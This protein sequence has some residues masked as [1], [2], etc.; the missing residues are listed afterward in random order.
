MG[1]KGVRNLLKSCRAR[2]HSQ[3]RRDGA[4]VYRLKDNRTFV[5]HRENQLSELIYYEGAYEPLESLIASKVILKNDV[6]LDVGANVGYYSALFDALVC[7]AGEVHSF[8]PGLKTFKHLCDTKSILNL[9]RTFVHQQAIGDHVGKCA[10]WIS[11]SGSDAQQSS[12]RVTALGSHTKQYEVDV[13][14]IDC[15]VDTTQKQN[16]RGVAFIK[17][18]IE[19]AEPAMLKGAQTL[20]CSADPPVWLIEHNRQALEE[21]GNSSSSLTDSFADYDIF[22]V[23]LTWPPSV[24]AIHQAVKWYG[25]PKH[26]PD[27]CN[28]IALPRRGRYAERAARLRECGLIT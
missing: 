8:E 17:C 1:R 4:F 26:L 23:P 22:F 15:F 5:L 21:H 19:G 25:E 28:L 24:M 13:T 10:F 9:Q 7:P 16:G 3:Y 27:E 20:F 6:V 11:T 14:T 2:V 12:V 18:D